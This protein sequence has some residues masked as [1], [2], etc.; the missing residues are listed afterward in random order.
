MN[1]LLKIL[2]RSL[3]PFGYRIRP[4]RGLNFLK[5]RGLETGLENPELG[6]ASKSMTMTPPEGNLDSLTVILRTCLRDNRR[7]HEDDIPRGT[8]MNESAIRCLHS[9]VSSINHARDMAPDF[10]IKLLILDD[11]SDGHYMRQIKERTALLQAPVE[12]RTTEQTGQG[13]SLYQAFSEGRGRDNLVYFVEDD[14]LHELDGI[15]RLCEFYRSIAQ[16]TG[17]HAVLYPQEHPTMYN[18]HYPSYIVM[19]ADRHW[20]S[21]RHATHTFLTHGKVVGTYWRYFEN[22]K[23]VGHPKKRQ[24]GSEAK[25]TNKLLQ[26]ICG[27]SPLRPCAVHFQGIGLLPPLYNWKPLWERNDFLSKSVPALAENLPL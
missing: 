4:S 18:N 16:R 15:F 8:T 12:I 1:D 6:A 24:R 2:S 7:R 21:M 11:R 25:T 14:Y 23:Y 9:L 3:E 17:S 19:G 26:H 20:R 5:V 27:Y 13:N 22:T 10:P